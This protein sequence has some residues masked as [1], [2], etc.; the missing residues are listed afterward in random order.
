MFDKTRHLCLTSGFNGIDRIDIAAQHSHMDLV[1]LQLP[2]NG[3]GKTGAVMACGKIIIADG[4]SECQLDLTDIMFPY[5][6]KQ[7]LHFHL[8]T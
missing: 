6:G 2:G 7:L 3:P 4:L 5:L 1:L 8:R